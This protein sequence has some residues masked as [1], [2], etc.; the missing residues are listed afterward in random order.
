MD[1]FVPNDAMFL[2]A[3]S[4]SRPLRSQALSTLHPARLWERSKSFISPLHPNSSSL[5]LTL[6]SESFSFL[7]V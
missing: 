3:F 1:L 7:R 5:F 6:L 4:Q 2:L